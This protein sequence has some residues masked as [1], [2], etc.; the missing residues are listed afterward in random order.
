MED[1]VVTGKILKHRKVA[2]Y[3]REGRLVAVYNNCEQ[4]STILGHNSSA[5][6]RKCASGH[7]RYKTCLG[8]VW[9][10]IE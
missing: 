8:Y 5:N 4:A 1:I 10:Y 6:I 7:K 3:T 9:K 2:Q